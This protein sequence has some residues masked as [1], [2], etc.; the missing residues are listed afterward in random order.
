MQ[1]NVIWIQILKEDQE[2][3][4]LDANEGGSAGQ[5]THTS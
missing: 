3:V 2:T 1:T 5:R 4:I